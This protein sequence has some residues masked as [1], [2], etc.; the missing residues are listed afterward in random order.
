MQYNFRSIDKLGQLQSG[1]LEAATADDA[2]MTLAE[3]ELVV[4][5]INSGSPDWWTR[6]NEQRGRAFTV[7]RRDVQALLG[8]LGQLVG[9][10]IR[11]EQ[12]LKLAHQLAEKPSVK[13]LTETI[14]SDLRKGMGL[15]DAFAK[16]AEIFPSHVVAAVRAAE[17]TGRIEETFANLTKSEA[18][19]LE[20]RDKMVSSLIYPALLFFMVV[21]A[22]IIVIFVV[23]PGFA[24]LFDL[25]DERIP[26]LTRIV[27]AIGR[28]STGIMQFAAI[29]GVLVL[30]TALTV[31][32]NPESKKAL[33]KWLM[34]QPALR[35]WLAAPDFIRAC[36][37]LGSSLQAGVKIDHALTLA[38][39]GISN[40]HLKELF[41]AGATA[42]RKGQ[43]L[44]DFWERQGIFPPVLVHFLRIG[45]QAGTFGPMCLTAGHHLT[46]AY[47]KRLDRLLAL[48]PPLVTLVLGGAVALLIGGVLLGM[49]SLNNVAL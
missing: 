27:L 19:I 26:M 33:D 30:A 24:P 35:S 17:K 28:E 38:A 15:G 4:V 41:A 49:I 13:T 31:L 37:V 36:Q 20:F 21:V 32:R 40:T 48:F 39:D 1:S 23:L 44:S 34:K 14:L 5:E 42:V 8:D 7:D 6:L 12:A 45:E 46:R 43:S 29:L 11:L 25:N 18:Q 10:G 3:R 2:L 9:S 47:Q 22:F 16:H